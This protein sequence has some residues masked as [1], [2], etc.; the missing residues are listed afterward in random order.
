MKMR[1]M[2]LAA[3]VL[4]ACGDAEGQQPAA[5]TAAVAAPAN[6]AGLP[7]FTQLVKAVGPAV[8]NITTTRKVEAP[9]L[10]GFADDPMFEFFRR[11]MPLPPGGQREFRAQGVGSG[12]I[13]DPGGY[14]LTN[15]HVVADAEEVTVRLAD[16]KREFKARVIGRDKLSD[17]ALLKIDAQGLPV[18]ST[19][20]S[21][22]LKVGEWVA[23]IGSPF[24]FDNT[25]T[26]GIV[27]AKERS[28][29]NETA[30]PF[31]Q[32]DVAVN[33]GNSG[34]PLL[35]TRGEVVGINSAIYSQ[36][37]GYMGVSFAIPID[38]AM[39]IAR[40]LRTE[41]R[42][43]RGRL[44]IGIQ[45]VTQELARSFGLDSARGA[46]IASVEKG[47]PADRAGL[48]PGDVILRFADDDVESAEQL[49]RLVTSSKPGT[50][51]QIQVWRDRR[52]QTVT[53]TVGEL[54]SEAVAQ[55]G[56]GQGQGQGRASG[57]DMARL[58]LSVS[59]LPPEDR[60][61]LGVEYGLVVENVANPGPGNPLQPGDVI[62]AINN[63]RFKSLEEFRQRLA[64]IDAGD[65]V[66]LLVQRGESTIYVPLQTRRG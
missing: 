47:G 24:G 21:D 31:I 17:V 63:D 38:A 39:D 30:V 34:G 65:N 58:G 41:G 60:R 61:K 52:T 15:A 44:G 33:P 62:L 50:Q 36:T 25:I 7:D 45:D 66:A 14:V 59:E 18:V 43:Q 1:A 46:L 2:L 53:A 27:S 12:F 11:F 29:P 32:T 42:V 20:D 56:Q 16:A 49:P 35:N 23:A 8:V 40:Q 48:A 26:A 5:R 3:V 19:G 28:L 64:Q 22:S 9:G 13:I 55:Q 54:P 51:V 6:A 37:G 57:Q 10:G 4:A